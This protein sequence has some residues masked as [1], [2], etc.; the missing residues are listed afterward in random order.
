MQDI[1]DYD[2]EY[3]F[4]ASES[5]SCL[6]HLLVKTLFPPWPEAPTASFLRLNNGVRNR[7]FATVEINKIF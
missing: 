4:T 7:R 3:A 5:S 2:P 1:M 6:V